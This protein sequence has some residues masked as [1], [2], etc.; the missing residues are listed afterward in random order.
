MSHTYTAE[1]IAATDKLAVEY[2]E[3]FFIMAH[4]GGEGQNVERAL[5]VAAR[6]DNVCGDLAVSQTMEGRVEWFVREIGA[7]KVLFGTDI[8]CMN[9]VA[10]LALIAMAEIS[11]DDKLDILGRNMRRILDRVRI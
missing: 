4:M 11:D 5:E 2:P 7:G 10:T 9:P 1:D 8:A 6:H 3:A